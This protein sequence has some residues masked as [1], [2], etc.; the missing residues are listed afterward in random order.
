M[1]IKWDDGKK[2]NNEIRK[3]IG[4]PKI[5]YFFKKTENPMV[6]TY[7]EKIRLSKHKSNDRVE[8]NWGE[9]RNALKSDDRM[10]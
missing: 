9:R 2:K 7:A 8:I 4:V 6:W 10:E 3:M 5:I 1:T